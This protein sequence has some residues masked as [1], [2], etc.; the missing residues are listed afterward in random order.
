MTSYRSGSHLPPDSKLRW[1]VDLLYA[2]VPGPC[3]CSF[4]LSLISGAECRVRQCMSGNR[5]VQS[6][7][8]ACSG[9]LH[10]DPTVWC[11]LMSHMSSSQKLAESAMTCLPVTCVVVCLCG[12]STR[13]QAS[14]RRTLVSL[15][16]KS[17]GEYC[18]GVTLLS[19]GG[20]SRVARPF[21]FPYLHFCE[22]E[23]DT[24]SEVGSSPQCSHVSA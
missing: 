12:F 16:G 21:W 4:F 6:K 23:E 1:S 15:G 11:I 19:V 14:W 10:W 17:R 8:V 2:A 24:V 9:H 7:A 5:R 20:S 3:P 13:I 22:W 18:V